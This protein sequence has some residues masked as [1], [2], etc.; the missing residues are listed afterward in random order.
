MNPINF[1]HPCTSSLHIALQPHFTHICIGP[2]ATSPPPFHPPALLHNIL[3]QRSFWG[4]FGLRLNYKRDKISIIEF[5]ACSS[6]ASCTH[7]PYMYARVLCSK[8][9]VF[10]SDVLNC[11][12]LSKVRKVSSPHLWIFHIAS[13]NRFLTE[14][15][16]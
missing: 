3:S 7:S 1:P 12:V 16:S 2:F 13:N 6:L 8:E 15:I 5:T 10:A 4:S 14:K 9:E 11:W